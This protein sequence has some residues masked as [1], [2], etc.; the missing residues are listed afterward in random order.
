MDVTHKAPSVPLDKQK[1]TKIIATLGPSVDSY[2]AVLA[3]V[4]AGVNG[5]R[6]NF[7]HGSYE[8]RKQQIEWVRKAAR[9]YGKPLALIQ[10]LQGPKIRLGD[11][12]G[13][14]TV[15]AGNEIRFKYKSDYESEAVVPLQYDL[16][17]K[18]VRGER[19]YIND[20]RLQFIISA[21]KSGEVIAQAQNDGVLIRRKGINLPDTDFDGD[22]ITAKDK[23][24][25]VFGSENDFDYVA[26]SFVQTSGDI[27]GLKSCCLT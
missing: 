6:L 17:K 12:E 24:D 2:A 7:S 26:L 21:V 5:V 8:E 18:V 3:L 15:T 14:I 16:S 20:G 19:M 10:D 27:A 4:K 23:K 22:I 13:I 1:R 11:F 25:I 9:E